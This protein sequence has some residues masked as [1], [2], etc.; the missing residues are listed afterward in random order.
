MQA[1]DILL[2]NIIQIY[3]NTGNDIDPSNCRPITLLSCFGKFTS[4]DN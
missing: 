4:I 2:E 1:Y 3:K